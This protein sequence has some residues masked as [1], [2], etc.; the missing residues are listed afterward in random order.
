MHILVT[1]DFPPKIGGIQ[2]Y[3][4]ELWSRLDPNSF[5]VLTAS[6]HDGA[7][8]FDEEQAARGIRIHRYPAKVLTPSVALAREVNRLAVHYGANMVIVDPILPLGLLGRILK[9]KY[10]LVAHGAEVTVPAGLPVAANAMKYILKRSEGVICAGEYPAEIISRLSK[11]VPLHQ[12]PPGVDT[13][14][15]QPLTAEM[16]SQ[17]RKKFGIGD[18]EE[19]VL[20]VSRLVPRK[21]MDVLIRAV[22][23][24]NFPRL[25]V[26]IAGQGRDRGR[27]ERIARSGDAKVTFLG[28]VPDELLPDLYGMA[29][30]FAMICRDRWMRM[31]QEGFGIVFLEAAACGIPQVAGKSGGS[32]EAVENHVTGFVVD[33]P[34]DVGSVARALRRLLTD[35]QL[36]LNM[37]EQSRIRAEESFN[38]PAL[39]VALAEALNKITCKT[40]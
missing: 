29:D 28:G 34:K 14:R 23:E 18:D 31:E 4:W 27:L 15:F 36:A 24:L 6:S 40:V 13:T 39:A 1:N 25:R 8:K 5:V 9:V 3:L 16:K 30:V 38:Y 22:A 37:G 32:N 7:A 20:S 35:E 17:A 33:R 21:G 26:V 11:G 10:A 12:I 2:S 19:I